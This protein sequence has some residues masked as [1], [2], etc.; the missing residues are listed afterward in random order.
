MLHEGARG[1]TSSVPLCLLGAGVI[2]ALCEA[3]YGLAWRWYHPPL[4]YVL[5]AGLTIGAS[6]VLAALGTLVRSQASTALA[7][8]AAVM[9]GLS[10]ALTPDHGLSTGEL[11]CFAA[12]VFLAGLLAS[13]IEPVRRTSPST[14]ALAAGGGLVLALLR[15]EG[16]ASLAGL[17]GLPLELGGALATAVLF[18]AVFA[19]LPLLLARL[20]RRVPAGWGR[21]MVLL[22][23][24][25]HSALPLLEAPDGRRRL[26]GPDD[27]LA[28]GATDRAPH[29]FLLV[30]DTVRADHLSVY[31]YE[32]DTTPELARWIQRR[33]NSLVYE[34]AYANGAWTVP[35]HAT[36]FTGLLPNEH[37]VH[38]DLR[39]NVRFLFGL[40]DETPTLA[41][42][43]AGAGYA[44]LGT[45]SN[46]WLRTVHGMRRG[47]DRYFLSP[48]FEPLP[49]AGEVLRQLLVPGLAAEAA[50]G[51]AR[52]SD[53]NRT[54][55]SMIGPWSQGEK[56]LFVFGNYG[57]AHGPYAPPP[58]FRG[59][60]QEP[61]VRERVRHLSKEL[62]SEELEVLEAR[63][64][65]EIL[66]LDFE[67]GRF[68]ERLDEL[69]IL[70]D[71]WVFVTSDHGEAFGEHGIL[72]HGTT[73]YNEVTRIPLV[74]F[75]PEG[76][77]LPA[78]G[79]AVSLVDV[80]RTIAAI[81]GFELDGPGRDLRRESPGEP[82]VALEFYGD[83]EKAKRH[84]DPA[85]YASRA[86]LWEN[87]KLIEIEGELHLFDVQRDPGEQVDLIDRMESVAERM[88]AMLPRYN[89]MPN[90]VEGTQP[91]PE[92][93]SRLQG[94]GYLGG[95]P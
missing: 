15:G 7:V 89:R 62:T 58:G 5:V 76:E 67:L 44:T 33:G 9:A 4:Y 39:G 8:W 84:G 73:L 48:N 22:L 21:A 2:F 91:D 81:G 1:R 38:F 47:F 71:S 18:G 13:R 10:H 19:G 42:G 61:A 56:P 36:L 34:Q 26:P 95:D 78:D 70:D 82:A 28:G 65:E 49:F 60:F 43:M 29:V 74:V 79:M 11:T 50:K 59:R 25:G 3:V 53:V 23:L 93:T 77:T 52:A 32:R 45:F 64:D 20:E 51:G 27:L 41:E 63:Y 30:L 72:E 6:A 54:L 80:A 86:V 75:P 83:A 69:G 31:G 14:L 12:T 92:A 35:S 57:D 90:A 17:G 85:R 37:G 87:Y 55:L 16:A 88:E 68:F 94:L 46:N 40:R 66:Y 24:V